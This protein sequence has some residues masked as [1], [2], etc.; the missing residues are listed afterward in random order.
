MGL[1]REPPSYHLYQWPQQRRPYVY[2]HLNTVDHSKLIHQASPQ[3]NIYKATYPHEGY[4]TS[5]F[6]YYNTYSN[7]PPGFGSGQSASQLPSGDLSFVNGDPSVYHQNQCQQQLQ[8]GNLYENAFG[9]QYVQQNIDVAVAPGNVEPSDVAA[10]LAQPLHLTPFH[11]THHPPPPSHHHHFQQQQQQVLGTSPEMAGH[12]MTMS[13]LPQYTYYHQHGLATYG[14]PPT[15]YVQADPG[16][17]DRSAAFYRHMPELGEQYQSTVEQSSGTM[18]NMG[19]QRFNSAPDL[20]VRAQGQQPDHQS[21]TLNFASE[22][23]SSGT[24]IPEGSMSSG[25]NHQGRYKGSSRGMQLKRVKQEAV[26]YIQ[27]VCPY[28]GRKSF[29]LPPVDRSRHPDKSSKQLVLGVEAERRVMGSFERYFVEREIPVF[30][31]CHYPVGGFLKHTPLWESGRGPPQNH[32]EDTVTLLLLSN[33]FSVTVVTVSIVNGSSEFVYIQKAVNL[34]ALKMKM[35]VNSVSHWLKTLGIRTPIQQVMAFPNLKK[36]M[37]RRI[38]QDKV[39]LQHFGTVTTLNQDHLSAQFEEE[40][41]TGVHKVQF[42][43]WMEKEVLYSKVTLTPMELK[44]LLGALLCPGLSKVS[45]TENLSSIPPVSAQVPQPETEQ[46][47]VDDVSQLKLTI[48]GVT[49][50]FDQFMEEYVQCYYPN[51]EEQTYRVPPIHFNIQSF[52]KPSD[53]L[54]E[55]EHPNDPRVAEGSLKKEVQEFS[56]GPAQEQNGSGKKK[57]GAGGRS[58]NVLPKDEESKLFMPKSKPYKWSV[59]SRGCQEC[60]GRSVSAKGE[61]HA[62]SSQESSLKSVEV[63]RRD[64][65]VLRDGKLTFVGGASHE[66]DTDG[67]R[68]TVKS[69]AKPVSAPRSGKLPLMDSLKLS[70]PS[71]SPPVSPVSLS[72][73]PSLSSSLD[74]LKKDKASP[75]SSPRRKKSKQKQAR[76]EALRDVD[77][78]T[79]VMLKDVR[80]DEGENRVVSALEL[81]GHRHGPMFIICAYQYNNYLNKLRE[82]MFSKG[83]A[84]RPVRAFGQTMRAEHDC[85]ILHKEY[86]IIVVCIKAIGDTFSVWGATEEG[87]LDSTVRILAKAV[88]QLE[89]EEAMIRHVTSD[90]DPNIACHKLIAL[91]NLTRDLVKKALDSDLADSTLLKKLDDLTHGLGADAFLCQDELPVK[92]RSVWDPPDINVVSRLVVWWSQLKNSLYSKQNEMTTRIF[93]QVIGRYCGLLSTV[94]VWTQTNPRIEVRSA[95]EAVRQC[96]QRFARFVL[97]PHQLKILTSNEPRVYLYGPPG[98][99]KTLLLLLKAKEWLLEGRTVIMINAREFSTSGFPLAHGL[100]R[101]IRMMVPNG[102]LERIDIDSMNFKSEI[103]AHILPSRCVIMDE[104]SGSSHEIVEHLCSLQLKAIWCAGLFEDGKPITARRFK[105]FPLDKILRCTPIVQSLLRHTEQEVRM[106]KPYENSYARTSLE[107]SERAVSQESEKLSSSEPDATSTEQ[108]ESEVTDM[109]SETPQPSLQAQSS[110]ELLFGTSSQQKDLACQNSSP[111]PAS[112]VSGRILKS[113]LV[114]WRIEQK[115][116]L[117]KNVVHGTALDVSSVDEKRG[118]PSVQNTFVTSSAL[119]GLPTDGPRP[120]IIDHQRHQ[121]VHLPSSCPVCGD[122]LFA[123]LHSMV[124]QDDGDKEHQVGPSKNKFALKS[125]TPRG[126]KTFRHFNPSQSKAKQFTPV[127]QKLRSFLDSRALTWSDVLIV[128]RIVNEKSVL[129]QTLRRNEVPVEVVRGSSTARI[130]DPNE[131]KLFVIEPKEVTGLERALIIFVPSE[132][133]DALQGARE[134]SSGGVDNRLPDLLLNNSVGRYTSDDRNAL[135][136][137]AS[138]SLSSLVLILP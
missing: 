4:G 138:R 96:A 97:L 114:A 1:G 53:C 43:D 75:K 41:S 34:A 3:K 36:S 130:E 120:H 16:P 26:R 126:G 72:S 38:V 17:Y 112:H 57:K 2:H 84:V 116:G 83:E 44:T 81:L 133:P 30:M 103:L 77:I 124:K 98:S 119:L 93:R 90:L 11:A 48:D 108:V 85:L 14:M 42:S 10:Q 110:S 106:S 32:K 111:V 29:C 113:D 37:M 51:V 7:P 121:V 59:C 50:G 67:G 6:P 76:A 15:V 60:A 47:T 13:E 86:G 127:G 23:M 82:E 74:G 136:Y 107:I 69:D 135:W 70:S 65:L 79:P 54:F 25:H 22:K 104:V 35:C 134:E 109:E 129:L 105:A 122:E 63:T 137:I 19:R 66:A 28:L 102:N 100:E 58:A 118:R 123:F 88:K 49:R 21:Q 52:Q 95:S 117:K 33:V 64:Q 91:P 71:S 125:N 115:Y 27:S 99:G 46:D 73:S 89:R 20:A 68:G 45:Y 9:H 31:L 5:R 56:S 62:G 40:W 94:E 131:K 12:Q 61:N 132:A 80:A 55:M 8:N 101:K 128:S 78:L 92:F 87:K 24:E 39:F 18:S